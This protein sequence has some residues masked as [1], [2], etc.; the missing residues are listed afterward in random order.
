MSMKILI[1]EDNEKQALQMSHALRDHGFAVEIDSNAEDAVSSLQVISYD[2]A[3]VDINLPN[4]DGLELMRQVRNLSIKIPIIVVSGMDD[5]RKKLA[6]FQYADD[7]MVKPF[8]LDELIL[9]L[10]AVKRR[11]SGFSSSIISY[12]NLSI[13]TFDR[14]AK[15]NNKVLH[16]TK[17]E[18]IMLELM[19]LRQGSL[20]SKEI[21]LDIMYNNVQEEPGMKI[22]DVYNFKLRKKLAEAEANV[23]IETSWG[24]GSML[25]MLVDLENKLNNLENNLNIHNFNN[26]EAISTKR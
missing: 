22:L 20:I 14:V 8:S 10:C 6:C 4:I 23:T 2:M 12:G 18:Y 16:L 11:C 5:N 3:V 25:V 15:V 1:V 9:R 21:F 19:M 24:R 13:D 17:K 26:Q 7:Y